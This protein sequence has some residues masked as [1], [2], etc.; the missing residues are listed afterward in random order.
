MGLVEFM[1]EEGKFFL[2]AISDH[3]GIIF[4]AL[5]IAFFLLLQRVNINIHFHVGEMEVNVGTMEANVEVQNSDNFS[6]NE[7]AAE[8][9]EEAEV[10]RVDRVDDEVPVVGPL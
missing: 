10:D 6:L 8:E 7:T 9:N 3:P 1:W 4:V 2:D 5:L